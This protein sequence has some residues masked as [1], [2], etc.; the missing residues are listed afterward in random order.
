MN[1][2]RR[3]RSAKT[4]MALEIFLSVGALFG[5]AALVLGPKGEIIPLPISALAGSPFDSYFVP[6]LILLGVLGVG[7]LAAAVLGW[8]GHPVAPF[9]AFAVGTALLIW[10]G[11]E[12]VIVGYTNVPPLQ[13]FYLLLGAVIVAVSLRWLTSPA[14]PGSAFVDPPMRRG[15]RR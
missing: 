11:V 3:R 4:A 6:G 13:P 14:V 12:I 10:L 7:P 5:G 8:R 2:E 15:A 1:S 9:A